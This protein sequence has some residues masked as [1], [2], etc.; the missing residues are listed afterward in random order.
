MIEVFKR[1]N[2]SLTCH[3]FYTYLLVRRHLHIYHFYLFNK[4]IKK[5]VVSDKLEL[6]WTASSFNQIKTTSLVLN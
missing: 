6:D 2:G 5:N 1:N 4:I 3:L